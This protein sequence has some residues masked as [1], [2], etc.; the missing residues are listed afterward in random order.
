MQTWIRRLH[1]VEDALLVVLLSVMIL[2]AALQILLRNFFDAGIVWADPLLRVMVLWVGLI[3]A[4]VATRSNK[5][6]RIDLVSRWFDRNTHRLLQAGVGQISA[7]T[8][9]VLAWF[10][11]R[12]IRLDYADGLIAFAGIPAWVLEC[13]VPIGF[14]LI[15]LRYFFMSLFWYRYYLKHRGV[16]ERRRS[17]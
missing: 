14:A 4:T 7:W 5:H 3:G 2:L 11:F 12:W 1:L 16:S 10:G 9:L 6:I 13:I 15:G 17:R 8:C